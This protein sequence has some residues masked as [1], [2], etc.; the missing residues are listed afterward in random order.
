MFI[1]F[2]LHTGYLISLQQFHLVII[3]QLPRAEQLY[4]LDNT[5]NDEIPQPM[6]VGLME[7]LHDIF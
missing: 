7:Y 6:D 5:I 4:F 2:D 1:H 3:V